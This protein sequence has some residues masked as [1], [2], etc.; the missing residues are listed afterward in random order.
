MNLN[1][2]NCDTKQAQILSTSTPVPIQ[3]NCPQMLCKSHKK[4]IHNAQE[5][6]EVKNFAGC[7]KL[8][9]LD[10]GMSRML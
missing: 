6:L 3:S 10:N 8:H 2:H 7:S 5:I 9:Q 1:K 4:P